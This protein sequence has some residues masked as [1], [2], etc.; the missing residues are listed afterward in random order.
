[1][2][3][4]WTE[5]YRPRRPEEVAGHAD[6]LA[7]VAKALQAPATGHM[8]AIFLW[9]PPGVGKTT[10]IHAACAS[11][12]YECVEYNASN[13]R[14]AATVKKIRGESQNKYSIASMFGA[15]APRPIALLFDEVDGKC[16]SD[17]I[18]EIIKWI[19]DKRRATPIFFTANDAMPSLRDACQTHIVLA[20]PVESVVSVLQGILAAEGLAPRPEDEL[21]CLARECLCDVR[22]CITM[23][24]FNGTPDANVMSEKKPIE[25]LL[26]MIEMDYTHPSEL[27][28]S[29]HLLARIL[30]HPGCSDDLLDEFTKLNAFPKTVQ[31][32]VSAYTK[33]GAHAQHGIKLAP[34]SALSQWNLY[35]QRAGMRTFSISR[36]SS[37]SSPASTHSAPA[38]LKA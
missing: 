36:S 31:E 33:V 10:I 28:G 34:F 4:L 13:F 2:A 23:L 37:V 3:T 17:A 14:S 30:L 1:M 5:K 24:Q 22:H 38:A 26:D 19:H 25:Q 18:S 16:G 11:A 21:A 35:K 9:G 27:A 32:S 12:G 20:P 15:S 29:N 7:A 6:I 8:P